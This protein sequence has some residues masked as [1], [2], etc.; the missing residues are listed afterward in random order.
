VSPEAQDGPAVRL[1]LLVGAGVA[2]AV[3]F[4]VV[5]P[6]LAVLLWGRP[7]F[8]TTVPYASTWAPTAGLV[9]TSQ[10]LRSE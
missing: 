7:L 2:F 4:E 8:S 1:E 3:D 9:T 5:D 10:I 6:P